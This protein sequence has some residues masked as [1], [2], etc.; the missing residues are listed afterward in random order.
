MSTVTQLAQAALESLSTGGAWP[1]VCETQPPP[2]EYIVFATVVSTANVSLRG[3]SNLQ[4]TRLQVD[5]YARTRKRCNEIAATLLPALEAVSGFSAVVD[6]STQH[7]FEAETR[8]RRH[9]QDF[10]IWAR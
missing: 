2:S 7:F 10:S 3:S 5:V 4:N 8:H 6:V 1:D 9:S